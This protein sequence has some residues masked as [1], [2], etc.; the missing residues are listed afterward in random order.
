MSTNSI[1]DTHNLSVYKWKKL[2][3]ESLLNALRLHRD[4]ILLFEA[5]SFPS[6]FQLSVL[7]LEE[8][9]KAKWIE[10]YYYSSITNCGFEEAGF[11]QQWLKLLYIHLEKQYA[12]VARDMFEY[13][14]SLVE[15]I[16]NGGLERRKQQAA[17]VGLDRDRK[18]VFVKDRIS[19]PSSIK[20]K[21]AKRMISW[22]NAEFVLIHKKLTF[23]EQYFGI[24]EMDEVMLSPSASVIFEWP[25]KS[26]TRSAKHRH[27]HLRQ[28][29]TSVAGS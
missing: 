11:E 16:K 1:T 8:F 23:Y 4:A 2:G 20:K 10:H 28:P 3:K 21:E 24:K 6:A 26:R 27:A 18:T 14:P 19:L 15:F 25:Y 9:A 5:N 17:Y 22:I 7:S 29:S 12:F 13:P